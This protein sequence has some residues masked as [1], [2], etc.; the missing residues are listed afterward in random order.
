MAEHAP[1][2]WQRAG[3]RKFALTCVAFGTY[4]L[5]LAT[6]LLDA[7]AYVTLQLG[8]IAA[9]ITGNS[10]GRYVEAKYPRTTE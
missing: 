6:H 8:T 1:T 2:G 9:Y 3:G 7:G 4:T 5:L 10:A